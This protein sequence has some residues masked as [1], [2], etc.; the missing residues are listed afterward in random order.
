MSDAEDRLFGLLTCPLTGEALVHIG[1]SLVTR[2]HRLRYRIKDVIPILLVDSAIPAKENWIRTLRDDQCGREDKLYTME[3]ESKNL[4]NDQRLIDHFTDRSA[5]YDYSSNWVHSKDNL[6]AIYGFLSSLLAPRVSRVLD[7]GSGTGAMLGILESVADQIVAADICIDMLRQNPKLR[8]RSVVA[9]AEQLPFKIRT[10]Q[11][12]TCRQALH[13]F[14]IHRSLSE[15]KRILLSS[16]VFAAFQIVSPEG[17]AGQWVTDLTRL[18]QKIRREVFTKSS[19]IDRVTNEGFSLISAQEWRDRSSTQSLL[20]YV[21]SE[22]TKWSV[23]SMFENVPIEV[24]NFLSIEQQGEH[25]EY[26][27]YWAFTAFKVD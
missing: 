18:R 13:Y 20:S 12:V 24:R 4:R 26:D 22:E 7:V 2:N 11:L 15:I 8:N 5:K 27:R 10:F 1:D 9:Q 3:F 25:F 21:Q 23:L 14:E 6:D 16:G 17:S 19:L